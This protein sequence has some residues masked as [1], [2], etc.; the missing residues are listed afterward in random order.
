MVQNLET[1]ISKKAGQFLRFQ[2]IYLGE[3]CAKLSSGFD[4]H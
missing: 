2:G 4:V 3:L 1:K